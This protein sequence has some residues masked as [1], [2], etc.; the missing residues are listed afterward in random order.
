[1]PVHPVVQEILG[2]LPAAGLAELS[3]LPHEQVRAITLAMAR[4]RGVGDPVAEVRELD[5]DGV[6]CRLYRPL[7]SAPGDVL[8]VVVWIHGGGWVIGSVESYDRGCR[9]LAN[10]SGAAVV[11][12]DYRLAPEHPFPAAVDDCWIAL[13]WVAA[14]GAE[15]GVDPTRLAVAGDSAGG[16]LS[17]VLTQLARDAGGP[18]IR[19]QVLVYPAVDAAMRFVS[20]EE[21]GTGLLLT[22]NDLVWFY[23]HYTAGTGVL[24]D[25]P[26][27]SPLR[28]VSL[29]GLPAAF[30]LTAEYDPLRDEGEAYGAALE[31]AGVPATV[32]RY[33]G[34]VHGFFGFFGQ[35]DVADRAQADVAAAV[36]AAL[37]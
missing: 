8:P 26:R 30:V 21:N 18:P 20:I 15:L 11:S 6:P 25:D 23:G 35:V 36:A 24:V 3:A 29:A 9:L 14:H 28:A 31:A 34:M 32:R 13:R 17:A 2:L 5:A 33:D 19:F 12:V 22:R 27:L 7:G 1:V 4:Q 10:G 37:G 16:N